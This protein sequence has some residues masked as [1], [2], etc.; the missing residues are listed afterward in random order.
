MFCLTNVILSFSASCIAA[1]L[2]YLLHKS[3]IC[4]FYV[5][6]RYMIYCNMFLKCAFVLIYCAQSAREFTAHCVLLP[7]SA[8]FAAQVLIFA[9]LCFPDPIN[10]DVM[11]RILVYWVYYTIQ[12]RDDTATHSINKCKITMCW[13]NY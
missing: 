13:I 5:L 1:A 7:C 2:L 8:L 9:C 11:P 3:W 4:L 12:G 6:T 10:E